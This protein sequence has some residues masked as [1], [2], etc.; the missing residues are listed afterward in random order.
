MSYSCF[1]MIRTILTGSDYLQPEV[2]LPNGG[3]HTVLI[4]SGM[5]PEKSPEFTSGSC[6]NRWR[7]DKQ[8]MY[9][10]I[11]WVTMTHTV[12]VI[13]NDSYGVILTITLL[14][15]CFKSCFDLFIIV[16]YSIYHLDK[17]QLGSIM[18]HLVR[19]EYNIHIST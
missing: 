1:I 17:I 11:V 4:Q 15:K 18:T 8:S 10:I 13:L 16:I 2:M 7:D 14:L 6:W 5:H 3:Q 9:D 12:W 19:S